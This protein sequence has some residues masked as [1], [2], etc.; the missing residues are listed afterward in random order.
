MSWL[1]QNWIWVALAIGVALYF[2]D[3]LQLDCG[4]PG[5]VVAG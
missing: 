1:S 2:F 3:T 5:L 4:E